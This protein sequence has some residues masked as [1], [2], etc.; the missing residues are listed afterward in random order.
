MKSWTSR[1]ESE[2]I[3]LIFLGGILSKNLLHQWLG[4]KEWHINL[5]DHATM[6]PKWIHGANQCHKLADRWIRAW[7]VEQER[8]F[9]HSISRSSTP[10]G[11]QKETRSSPVKEQKAWI[12]HTYL[13]TL[14]SERRAPPTAASSVRIRVEQKAHWQKQQEKIHPKPN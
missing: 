4:I 6:E 13:S 14:Q 9:G 3:F 2:A 1:S 10:S 5:K 7:T 8:R 12:E 11:P